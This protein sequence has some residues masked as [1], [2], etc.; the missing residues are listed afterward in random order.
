V[1]TLPPEWVKDAVFYQIFPDRFAASARLAKPSNL[2]PWE[3]PPTVY[4]FKGGDLLGV[5]ERLDYLEELG[6][7]AIYF[8]PIFQSAANHRYHTHDYYR[9]DPL[10][11]GD[12]AF[13]ALL[14][15]CHARSIRV[16]LDG[17]FNHASRGFY[18]FNHILENGPQSPYVDWFI[19]NG[20]PLHA[21]GEKEANYEAWWGMRELPKL[22]TDAPQVREFI[23]GV[24]EYW[25]RQGIDGWRLDVP[26]DIRT[27]GFWEE[28]R[29]RVKAVN[30]EAYLVAEIW[31]DAGQWLQGAH[32]DAVMNYPF[33]RACLGFFG[34]QELRTDFRPGG[35]PLRPLT[36]VEFAGEIDRLLSLYSWEVT[37]AQLNLLSSHDMPR[38]LTLV[39]GDERRLRLATLFQMTFPGAPC[40][41]YGDEIGL[42]G[43]DDPDCRR[44]FPW[45]EGRWDA[46]LLRWFRRCVALRHRHSVLRRGSFH[47]LLAEASVYAFARR[48]NQ[49]ALAVVFNAGESPAEIALPVRELGW[50]GAPLRDLLSERSWVVSDGQVRLSLD[51]LSAAILRP[52]R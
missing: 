16:V 1:T 15:A 39:G 51:P 2:E 12:A 38:F 3:S 4:G 32:F 13:R 45:D 11:G 8:N 9:V 40:I 24:A 23:M 50:E 26:L 42:E 35:F 25:L 31:E 33:D 30:P 52:E 36:G 46:D 6:I 27:P 34:G 5:L 41:Y 18:Q 17:V 29:R 28:F 49:E 48:L 10:L 19:V 22:N 44:S 43:G 20:F 37:Q 21:Y 47:R 7:T 14:D